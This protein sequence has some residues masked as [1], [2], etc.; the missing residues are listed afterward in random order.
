MLVKKAARQI[1][2]KERNGRPTSQLG[3]AFERAWDTSEG[4]NCLSEGTS[5]TVL[6]KGLLWLAVFGA[7]L[8]FADGAL[9]A[10]L[11]PAADFTWLLVVLTLAQFF[12]EATSFEQF[13]EAPKSR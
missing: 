3:R 8:G 10:E 6:M 5:N 7:D 12:L 4:S 1:R 11:G 2:C 13:L 9:L